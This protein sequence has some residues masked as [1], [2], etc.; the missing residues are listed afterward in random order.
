MLAAGIAYAQDVRF[1]NITT[2]TTGGG[3]YPAGVA[4]AKVLQDKLGVRASAQSSS[5]SVENVDVMRNKEANIAFIQVNHVQQANRGT[6]TFKGKEKLDFMALSPS[7]V[8]VDQILVRKSANINSLADFKGKRF[9]MGRV[10]SGTLEYNRELLTAAN[11]TEKD[12]TPLY[13]GATEC[14]T[15]LREGGADVTNLASGIPTS[16]Y[17]ETLMIAGDDLKF[18]SLTP[19]EQEAYAKASGYKLPYVMPAGSYEGQTE[20]INT[21]MHT[22]LFTVRSDF[23]E[24]LGYDIV[25]TIYENLDELIAATGT[26]RVL[27]PQFAYDAIKKAGVPM[28]PGA[29]RYYKEVLG[30]KA[31]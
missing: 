16:G 5:G 6:D 15:L 13:L 10:G 19:E 3:A 1:I 12:I 22:N 17:T 26:Y 31:K 2:A 14:L 27:N 7:L 11:L 8:S 28:H 18:L 24:Q 21:A 23:P 25:K 4:L 20:N 30:E 29:E 9:C